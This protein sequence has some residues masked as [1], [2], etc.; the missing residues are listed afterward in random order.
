M[1]R[2]QI[3]NS[4]KWKSPRNFIITFDRLSC[5]SFSR[6]TRAPRETTDRLSDVKADHADRPLVI[7]PLGY[8]EG[9]AIVG[10]KID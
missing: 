5:C 2:A 7:Q 8:A 3:R 1:G 4:G 10:R 9:G 6:S